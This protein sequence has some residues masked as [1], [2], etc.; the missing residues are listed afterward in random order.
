MPI[1]LDKLYA[2]LSELIK[3]KWYGKIE[4]N[5]ENGIIVLIR[6]SETIK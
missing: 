3:N 4:I 5:V 2:L 1:N 6:K